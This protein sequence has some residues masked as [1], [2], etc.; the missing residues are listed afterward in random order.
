V[1][2]CQFVLSEGD[3]GDGDDHAAELQRAQAFAEDAPRADRNDER[4][5]EGERDDQPFRK[6]KSLTWPRFLCIYTLA[7]RIRA[8]RSSH[9]TLMRCT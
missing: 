8:C 3:T 4:R 7:P 6:R 1:P 9:E 5:A 2:L